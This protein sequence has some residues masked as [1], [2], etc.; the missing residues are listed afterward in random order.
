MPS[1][2][3]LFLLLCLSLKVVAAETPE[4]TRHSEDEPWLILSLKEGQ[5][6]ETSFQQLVQEVKRGKTRQFYGL[7]GKR[8]RGKS[9]IQSVKHNG[10]EE[11]LPEEQ[12]SRM[13]EEAAITLT[14]TTT[15]ATAD[16]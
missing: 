10:C 8:A 5:S 14:C 15:T 2:L 4:P 16:K 9:L 13:V 1:C 3:A 7:M 6:P 12:T 11:M